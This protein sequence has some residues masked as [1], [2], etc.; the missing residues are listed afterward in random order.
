MRLT[1]SG[2]F[3]GITSYPRSSGH[4][5]MT[6]LPGKVRRL[7]LFPEFGAPLMSTR[8]RRVAGS[9]GWV[10]G[11]PSSFHAHVEIRQRR[12]R[13]EP[14]APHAQDKP[15]FFHVVPP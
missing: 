4:D 7:V 6:R 3:C 13:D 12:R 15:D 10:K 9:V 1:V 11:I 8:V 14:D 5:T 2:S